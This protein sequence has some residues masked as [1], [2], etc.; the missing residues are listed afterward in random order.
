MVHLHWN[1]LH[2]HGGK[3]SGDVDWLIISKPCL[4]SSQK[5]WLWHQGIRNMMYYFTILILGATVSCDSMALISVS[6]EP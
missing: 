4:L 2:K 6:D 3:Q 5:G 1:T